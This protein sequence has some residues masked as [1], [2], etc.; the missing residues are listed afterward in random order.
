MVKH[1]EENIKQSFNQ[2]KEDYNQLKEELDKTK[3]LLITQNKLILELFNQIKSLSSKEPEFQEKEEFFLV[4]TGNNGVKQTNKQTN[5]KH[6]STSL[7]TS[8]E[9]GDANF[10]LEKPV[11]NENNQ[12]RTI[13]RYKKEESFSD[14]K[15]NINS[16][17]KKLSK[18]ELRVF[19]AVYQQEEENQ[20]VTY[21]SLAL[22]MNLTESCIRGYI[23]SL[24]KK[25]VPLKKVKINN[26]KVIIIIKREFKEL[27]L[28]NKLI[29]LYYQTDPYQTRLFDVI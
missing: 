14:Y 5:T 26:K 8:E 20:E 29:S 3:K 12:E 23:A 25:K 16:T 4:S 19:L 9:V 11:L 22:N 27:N 15:L 6:L 7:S 17:F 1:I 18:Q 28:K 21:S 10:N 2:V 13:I 24:I